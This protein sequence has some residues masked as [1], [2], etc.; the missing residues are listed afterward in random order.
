MINDN[1]DITHAQ[2]CQQEEFSGFVLMENRALPR[3]TG[4]Y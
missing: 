2:L 3:A 1:V 4:V